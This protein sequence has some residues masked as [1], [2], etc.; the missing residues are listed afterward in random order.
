[1]T[2]NMVRPGR[3]QER[4]KLTH[5]PALIHWK[6]V[7]HGFI[8]GFSRLIVGLRAS[9]NNRA[10]TVLSLFLDS[11]EVYGIPSRIRGDHG[12]E[13]VD[14]ARWMEANRGLDRGSYIWGR[15]V[16]E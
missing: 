9:N 8:D 15:L 11:I 7:I 13:N 2:V 1:M 4:T 5:H 3:L 6:I 10:A 16:H 14:V 12:V